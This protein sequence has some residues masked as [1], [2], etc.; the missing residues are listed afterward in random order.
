MTKRCVLLMTMVLFVL[1]QTIQTPAQT[2]NEVSSFSTPITTQ[3]FADCI[4]ETVAIT[5]EAK[6]VFKTVFDANGGLHLNLHIIAKGTGLGQTSGTRY[7]FSQE[8]SRM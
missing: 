6:F 2:E 5:G 8:I 4:G 1:V 7:N 3:I